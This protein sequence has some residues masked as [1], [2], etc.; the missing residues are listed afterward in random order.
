MRKW[1]RTRM[2]R[3]G[4]DR[5]TVWELLPGSRLTTLSLRGTVS[6]RDESESESQV[7]L[8]PITAISFHV[9]IASIMF[10]SIPMLNYLFLSIA[11]LTFFLVELTLFTFL[12]GIITILSLFEDI[13]SFVFELASESSGVPPRSSFPTEKSAVLILGAQEGTSITHSIESDINVCPG[14]RCRKKR[15]TPI[16]RVGLYRLCFVPQSTR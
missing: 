10:A 3:T 1:Q 7:K 8:Y 11:Y 14:V 2:V 5:H 6:E 13:S 12:T 16:L 15:C 4:R 9:L